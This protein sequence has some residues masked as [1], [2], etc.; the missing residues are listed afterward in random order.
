L[1][2]ML[3]FLISFMP[4]PGASGLGEVLF[5]ALFSGTVKVE[6]VGVAVVLWR[7][8][9]QYLSA[10]LGAF[11]TARFFSDLWKKLPSKQETESTP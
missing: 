4:T 7:I 2:A 5:I 9:Y 6:L 3:I 10:G 1:S 8:F 11:F